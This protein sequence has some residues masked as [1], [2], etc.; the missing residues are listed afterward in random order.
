[1]V[2]SSCHYEKKSRQ[3]RISSNYP[4]AV[5][6]KSAPKRLSAYLQRPTR[7]GFPFQRLLQHLSISIHHHPPSLP[8]SKHF[9]PLAKT[10]SKTQHNP[11]QPYTYLKAQ[12][13]PPHQHVHPYRSSGS[14]EPLPIALPLSFPPRPPQPSPPHTQRPNQRTRRPRIRP[15]HYLVR[16]A[17]QTHGR[18]C[19]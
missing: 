15:A 2:L 3:D 12:P 11:A 5:Y 4:L 16:L 6:S 17:E 19:M 8:P 9:S 13:A 14:T 18:T 10:T 7:F 1:M